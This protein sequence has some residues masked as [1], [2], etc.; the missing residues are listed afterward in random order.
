MVKVLNHKPFDRFKK[1]PDHYIWLQL[2]DNKGTYGYC[3]VEIIPPW[4]SIHTEITRWSHKI[5]R[6]LKEDW[7]EIKEMCIREGATQAIASNDDI[8][9]D[10]WPK[11]IRLF[12]FPEPQPVLMSKQEL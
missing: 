11:F 8:E 12:G 1:L 5:A 10:R 7:K 2:W 3:G 6:S 4:A 9:Y